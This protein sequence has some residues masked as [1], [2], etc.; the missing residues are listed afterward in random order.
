MKLSSRLLSAAFLF[1]A[2]ACS[3][4]PNFPD[5]NTSLSGHWVSADTVDVFTALDLH[6]TQA[7]SGL[8][9]G[10]WTGKTRITNGKC[11]LEFG[12]SPANTVSGS[13]LSLSV[14]LEILGVGSFE[15]QLASRDQ[16]TGKIVRLGVFYNLNLRRVD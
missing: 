12:C 1:L 7:P 2:A 15:G 10:N 11:D 6:V 8:I 3:K 5:A 16:L 13:N 14:N 4:D 9:A